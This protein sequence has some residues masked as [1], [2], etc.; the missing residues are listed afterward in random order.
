MDIHHRIDVTTFYLDQSDAVTAFFRFVAA[1]DPKSASLVLHMVSLTCPRSEAEL[2]TC[3]AVPAD[4]GS[5]TALI[6]ALKARLRAKGGA[7]LWL[8]MTNSNHPGHRVLILLFLPE[9][10]ISRCPQIILVVEW[11]RCAEPVRQTAVKG[12]RPRGRRCLRVLRAGSGIHTN[13]SRSARGVR[14][15]S[16]AAPELAGSKSLATAKELPRLGAGQRFVD[17][18]RL[19]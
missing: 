15:N 12:G 10:S 14:C 17:G 3:G 18:E 7:R 16:R 9:V 19:G 6:E 1:T 11:T 5:G 2:V 13:P 4:S 8:T